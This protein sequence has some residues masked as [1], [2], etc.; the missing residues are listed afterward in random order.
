MLNL[1]MIL[2]YSLDFSFLV[3]GYFSFGQLMIMFY[4]LIIHYQIIFQ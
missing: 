2:H 4:P 1:G 3:L